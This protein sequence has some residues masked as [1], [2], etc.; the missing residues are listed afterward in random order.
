[1]DHIHIVVVHSSQTAE[2]LS[3]PF[4]ELR[5][6][7]NRVPDIALVIF[8]GSGWDYFHTF[9]LPSNNAFAKVPSIFVI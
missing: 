3:T 8:G 6:I 1:V 5:D 2:S 9:F 7:L 4:S